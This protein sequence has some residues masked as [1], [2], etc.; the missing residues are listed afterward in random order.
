MCHGIAI[1]PTVCLHFEYIRYILIAKIPDAIR[2][3]IF[4]RPN[5]SLYSYKMGTYAAVSSPKYRI[6]SNLHWIELPSFVRIRNMNSF[7][8]FSRL[9]F[10]LNRLLCNQMHLDYFNVNLFEPSRLE[11]AYAGVTHH[12]KMIFWLL[13][14]NDFSLFPFFFRLFQRNQYLM[15]N[16]KQPIHYS[17]QLYQLTTFVHATLTVCS[18]NKPEMLTRWK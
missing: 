5:G 12:A 6:I 13:Y 17:L 15:F 10:S 16:I 2:S 14:Q 11:S 9:F 3:P 18:L 1:P 4:S 7:S 8:I